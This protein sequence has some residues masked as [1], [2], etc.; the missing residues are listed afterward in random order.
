MVS[1]ETQILKHK[2]MKKRIWIAIT[3]GVLIL[4]GLILEMT[5][6]G[7]MSSGKYAMNYFAS[8]D[9]ACGV[10]AAGKFSVGFFS[11]GIFSC[12]IFSLGIFNIGIYATGFFLLAYRKKYP[13]FFS[14][15]NAQPA[16]EE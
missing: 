14:K 8:G 13:K 5:M 1:N 9:Y 11:V 6:G 16:L 15:A 10:F 3:A 4:I 12:G 2:T 7:M